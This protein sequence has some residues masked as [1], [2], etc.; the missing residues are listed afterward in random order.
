MKK[1]ILI[2]LITLLNA[3]S[4][5]ANSDCERQAYNRCLQLYE[6]STQQ[7]QAA[8][9]LNMSKTEYC[10]WLAEQYCTPLDE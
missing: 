2:L 4:A 5:Q 6:T 10:R 9:N 8:R 7:Q 3:Q 1:F